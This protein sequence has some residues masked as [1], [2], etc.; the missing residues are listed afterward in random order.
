MADI[1][2]VPDT[3]MTKIKPRQSMLNVKKNLPE[4]KLLQLLQKQKDDF[5]KKQKKGHIDENT[6]AFP[7]HPAMKFIPSPIV[8]HKLL[9]EALLEFEPNWKIPTALKSMKTTQNNF[10]KSDLQQF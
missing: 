7:I 6:I 3:S 5:E 2:G 1:T 10:Q 4:A 8:A 9:F